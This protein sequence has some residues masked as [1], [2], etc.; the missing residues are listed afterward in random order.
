MYDACDY[1]FYAWQRAVIYLEI[2]CD[3]DSIVNSLLEFSGHLTEFTV[4]KE[5]VETLPGGRV[6]A[7]RVVQPVRENSST[8]S[9]GILFICPYIK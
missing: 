3:L 9:L 4:I 2:A 6:V 1:T 5:L 7:G 8:V